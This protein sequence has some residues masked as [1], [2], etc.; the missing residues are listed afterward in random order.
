MRKSSVLGGVVA[1]VMALGVASLAAQDEGVQIHGFA[2]QGFVVSSNNNYLGMPT[3]NFSPGWT[4][5]AVNLND[6]VG[7]KLRVGLQLHYTHLGAFGGEEPAID[8][9]LAD[10]RARP[11]L[12]IRA[13]KVKIRW[14]L[15]NDT[16]DYDPGYLWA[17]LPEPMYAVDWRSTDLAQTGVEV[18]GRVGLGKKLGKLDYSVYDGGYCDATNDGIVEG[19]LEEGLTFTHVPCGKTPGGDLRWSPPVHGL[20]VGASLMVYNASG[21]LTDG[22]LREPNTFWPTVYAQYDFHKA[23][24]SGQ[25]MKLVEYDIATEAGS[26]PEVD[27]SDNR[28]WFAMGGY[29]LTNK[30]EAGAYYTRNLDVSAGD[31]SDPGSYFHDWVVSGR[32]DFSAFAYAKLEGHFIDGTGLGFYDF[33][34]P[35]DLKPHTAVVVTKI[36]FTF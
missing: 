2:T 9:A 34:N 1:G 28:A 29:H 15:Y 10:Y 30:F 17:L 32:Y 6:N 26:A 4:E 11:W 22:T 3:R 27:A 8:W 21:T 14:G 36:G 18:Y 7:D 13:G 31:N 5:A 12:G 24:F 33:D 35:G 20:K 16:Q 25:L 23:F 19:Y